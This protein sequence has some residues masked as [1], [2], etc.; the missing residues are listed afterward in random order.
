[1][2]PGRCATPPPPTTIDR[3][4]A[5][6]F[7][8]VV[9]DRVHHPAAGRTMS[10]R[11]EAA[12][13]RGYTA[14][15]DA[16]RN[17]ELSPNERLV[18]NALATRFGFSRGAM[19][20]ALVRLEQDGVVVREPNRG[21]HV[22]L[23]S[24]QEAVEILEARAALEA[25]AARHAAGRATDEDVAALR[26]IGAEMAACHEHGDLLG[27][28]GCNARLHR[29]ILEL[30]GH[31]TVQQLAERLHSHMVRF[32]YRTVLVAGRP[33]QSL[34]EHHAIIEAIAAHDG[35]AAE[36]AMRAHLSNVADA[37]RSQLSR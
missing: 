2:Q 26:A 6:R 34:R 16:I 13:E 14:L 3:R 9:D 30:S 23:V 11:V 35:D 8:D 21:A 18:E 33:P 37:L 20:T 32:Q 25:I 17:G 15:L 12:D 7:A 24:E 4:R 29:R 22:R 28:S 19:R 5:I 27:M 10:T 1:L 36:A 31:A